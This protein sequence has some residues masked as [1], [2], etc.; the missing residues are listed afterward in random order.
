MGLSTLGARTARVAGAGARPGND[1]APAQARAGLRRKGA[2]SYN[3]AVLMAAES[4]GRSE[5]RRGDVRAVRTPGRG[6]V[7]THARANSPLRIF[8]PKVGR[9]AVW[10]V[11]TTLGGGFVGGDDIMLSID[12]EEGATALLTSQASTKVSRS[13]RLSSQR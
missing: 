13:S 5:P 11:T 3:R 1:Q 6:S 12:V 9:R 7:L 2:C 8:S 4:A 10:V